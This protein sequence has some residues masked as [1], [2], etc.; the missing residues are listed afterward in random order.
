MT[1]EP[2]T[3]TTGSAIPAV[4]T[5]G[6]DRRQDLAAWVAAALLIVLV[7]LG[8]AWD[9]LPRAETEPDFLLG[10]IQVN[11]SSNDRWLDRLAATGFNTVS[12]TD[13]AHQGDWDS[14][15][16][17]FDGDDEGEIREI[18]AAKQRGFQV[19]LILRVALDHAFPRNE[20][21]WHG[22]IQPKSEAELDEW[23]YRYRS[24][25]H[26]WAETA[27]REGVDLLVIGSEMNALTSTRPVVEMPALE[28]WYLNR[29]KRDEQLQGLLEHSDRI[30]QRHLVPPLQQGFQDLESY[31]DARMAT[32]RA[33]AEKVAPDLGRIN[34]RRALLDEHWRR[35]I[36]EVREIY[37]GPLGYAANFD[38]YREVG[39]WDALDVMGINAY[40]QL[41]RHLVPGAATEDLEPLLQEG[42][43]EVL[44]EILTF[45]EERG[46]TRQPVMFT[47]M[48]FT[49]RADSTIEPWASDGFSLV[50]EATL[51]EALAEMR[52]RRAAEK[53]RHE[54]RRRAAAE[55][56]KLA[57][58]E[59]P[60]FPPTPDHPERL[61]IWEDRPENRT[62][63][64]LA[65]RA[66]HEVLAELKEPLLR[67]I[68]YWKL[69]S[70]PWHWDD[71]PFVL[72]IDEDSDDPLLRE[73]QRFVSEKS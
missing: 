48:G 19:V 42:W 30:E 4:P 54:A 11:E 56:R 73:L 70:H 51:D 23:F 60:P 35:L 67:G 47:E 71:E 38:Q 57:E 68:L 49:H 65:V 39:F 20:F 29:D 14:Y 58:T 27:E 55:G 5:G 43:R 63:R 13:Y 26:W 46:L 16:L 34:H 62:E 36:Q 12:V 31:M 10:G 72:L 17:W 9:R 61:V 15:N 2:Q 40:F 69:S 44:D 3:P 32:E 50:P 53:A 41:R 7:A 37:H 18:R 52:A 25:V 28:E 1:T 33:W 66:L 64:A 8:V 45:R 22:M 59:L 24:F 6:R 21:L